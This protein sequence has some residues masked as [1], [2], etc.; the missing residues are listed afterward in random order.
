VHVLQLSPLFLRVLC[1]GP[2]PRCNTTALRQHDQSS[3]EAQNGH[4]GTST[5]GAAAVTA[6]PPPSSLPP[7]SPPPPPVCIADEHYMPTLLASY[8][9]DL[10]VVRKSTKKRTEVH[11]SNTSHCNL[12]QLV[13][14]KSVVDVSAGRVTFWIITGFNTFLLP[15]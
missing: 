2:T 8:G 15:W 6:P 13:I 4:S 1:T 10:Q 12:F 9:L 3:D 14:G 11:V 7:P 5:R